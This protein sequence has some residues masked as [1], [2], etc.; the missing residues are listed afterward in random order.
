M[1]NKQ[2]T[3]LI[4][5]DEETLR[6][7]LS[8]RCTIE[9]FHVLEARDGEEGL[10]M[11]REQHP[12]I[13]LLDLIMPKMDGITMLKKMKS[14]PAISDIPVI[15]LTNLSDNEAVSEAME[16]GVFDFLIKSN[17]TLDDVLK[18]VRAKIG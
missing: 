9:H 16:N 10:M 5:E 17:Y 15:V 3:I 8:I 7:V 13:I 6:H 14:D 12:D 1:G 18:K 2:K 4:V 11:T